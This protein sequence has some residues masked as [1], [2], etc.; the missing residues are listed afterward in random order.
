MTIERKVGKA[1]LGVAAVK[2]A[3]HQRA[4]AS[5]K[6]RQGKRLGEIVVG[7]S[8]ESSDPLLNQTSRGEHQYGSFD[9]LLPQFAA[10]LEPAHAGQANI[11]ENS[12]VGDIGGEWKGLLARLGY[13]HSVGIFPQGSG[14]KAGNLPFILDQ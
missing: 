7:A 14:D 12:V 5:E 2:T 10:N 1:Q 13:V 9:S 6:F 3:A 11:Q 8:V 4:H